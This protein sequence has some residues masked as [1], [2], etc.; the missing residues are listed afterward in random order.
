M[1]LLAVPRAFFGAIFA[2]LKFIIGL[3]R[4]FITFLK[5]VFVFMFWHVPRTLFPVAGTLLLIGGLCLFIISQRTRHQ[6]RVVEHIDHHSWDLEWA[7]DQDRPAARRQRTILLDSRPRA[8]AIAVADECGESLVI[9]ELDGDSFSVDLD[10]LP[11]VVPTVVQEMVPQF[12]P[13]LSPRIVEALLTTLPEKF[14]TAELAQALHDAADRIEAQS[15]VAEDHTQP[16]SPSRI[17]LAAANEE[18]EQASTLTLQV[19]YEEASENVEAGDERDAE[20][21]WEEERPSWTYEEPYR[22]GETHTQVVFSDPLE[23]REE[24]QA[25]LD[26]KIVNAAR[27]YSEWYLR[28]TGRCSTDWFGLRQLTIPI[29]RLEKNIVA[30]HEGFH[31]SETPGVGRRC[32]TYAK[33]E[34]DPQFRDKMIDLPWHRSESFAR[35]AQTGAVYVGFLGLL[36]TVFV[37]LKVDDVTRGKYR[38]RIGVV[39]AFCTAVIAAMLLLVII[40]H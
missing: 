21:A 32:I 15:D 16:A 20:V 1:K 30:T 6:P 37:Y 22:A 4:H 2:T 12:V 34:F 23:S 5:H 40:L 35:S 33:L 8:S 29:S 31:D 17:K 39:A 19:E 14:S 9:A 28:Q 36:A 13:Y 25:H 26:R 10:E 7:E 11:K 24:C 18:N 38:K 3:L 27:E